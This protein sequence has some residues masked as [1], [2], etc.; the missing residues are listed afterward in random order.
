MDFS[1][2]IPVYNN[3]NSLEGT[4]NNI[5]SCFSSF[6]YKYQ[7][8]F[9]D[10]GS[11]DSSFETLLQLKERNNNIVIVQLQKNYNQA[12]AGYAGFE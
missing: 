5:V 11:N 12:I 1:V 9:V 4:Y 2:V 7:V 10:D 8:I 6:S 3:R